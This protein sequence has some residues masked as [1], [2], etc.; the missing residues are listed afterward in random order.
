MPAGTVL[1]MISTC[2]PA[3]GSSSTTAR[4]PRE[5][6]V[7]GA[8][9]R[10]VDA[11]EEQPGR[12]EQLV[13]VGGEGEALGVAREQLVELGLVDRRL[14]PRERG[15]LLREDVAGDDPVAKIGE[16][17][18]RHQADPAH[19]DH[20]DRLFALHHG[21]ALPRFFVGFFLGI[22]TLA[23]RAMPSIW[24]LVSDC[25]RLLETQ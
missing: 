15:D 14:A 10:R 18:R 21:C 19:P 20:A 11:D 9:R 1:F 24:S 5:V 3:A 17:G 22:I 8:G 7:A 23:D 2:S 13:H 4:H 25:S 6:G 16:A 12:S